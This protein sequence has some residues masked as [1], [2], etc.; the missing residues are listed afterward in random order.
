MILKSVKYR[1]KENIIASALAKAKPLAGKENFSGS[2]PAPFIGRIGYPEVNVGILSL[3]ERDED[4]W[5]HDAPI[6]WAKTGKKISEIVNYRTQM[7]N[8]RFKSSVKNLHK[9]TS[10]AQEVSM[11]KRAV[12]LDV[13]LE[14]KPKLQ[15]NASQWVAPMG[16]QAQLKKIEVE[17][18]PRIPTRVQKCHDDT[19]LLS[20]EA[21][22]NLHKHGIDEVWLSRMLSTATFGI[23][24]NRKLVPTRWS[25]TATDDI[26]GKD[27]LADVRQSPL[28]NEWEAYFGAY[29]GNYY[30]VL[31]SPEIWSYEL[32]EIYAKPGPA[33]EYSTD[34]EEYRGRKTYAEQCAGG[35]YTVRL[36]IAE[37][38][39]QKKRQA[40]CLVLRFI[41]DEYVMPL[42]VWVT[43]EATRKA[44]QSQPIQIAD[45]ELMLKY[46]Q[47]LARK[48]FG[49][50][51]TEII[52]RRKVEQQTT[53][54]NLA[55]N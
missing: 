11:A 21:L 50:D 44:L 33:L 52:K 20:A 49:L 38:L 51:I 19:D 8:S 31:M 55:S 2:A 5:E 29:L 36:A 40:G 32:F 37:H 41:T 13:K 28:I 35:Y 17:S 42:G 34:H 6:H 45:K 26:L 18:N 48:K 53:L 27:Q 24:K 4:A 39:R 3:T 14:K 30:L 46:A 25:I 7:I 9:L 23:G 47:A 1:E 10:V 12:D 16:P 22:V 54:L 43:R 15:F